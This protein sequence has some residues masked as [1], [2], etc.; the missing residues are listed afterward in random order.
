VLEEL[1]GSF[2][3][4][5]DENDINEPLCM[6]YTTN[7]QY[8]YVQSMT[9]ASL[10]AMGNYVGASNTYVHTVVSVPFNIQYNVRS[11]GVPIAKILFKFTSYRL[12]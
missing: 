6:N 3:L 11:L 8:L 7:T 9:F 12:R 5:G 2:P 4:V 10:S 1:N